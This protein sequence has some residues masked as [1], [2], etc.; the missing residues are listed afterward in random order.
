MLERSSRAHSRTAAVYSA[1]MAPLV[2]VCGEALIDMLPAGPVPGGGAANTAIALARLGVQVEFVGGLSRDH[3]GELLRAHLA[4]NGVALNQV[5]ESD[6]PTALALI[7]VDQHGQAQYTFSLD[8]TATFTF[9]AQSLP[10]SEPDVLHIGSLVTIVEPAASA[11]YLWAATKKAP[12]LFDPN[13]RPAVVNDLAR[14]RVSVERWAAIS[15]VIKLSDEDLRTLYP[16]LDEVSAVARLLNHKVELL[17]LT[18]GGAG[19]SAFTRTE[20]ISVPGVPVEVVDTVG[21]GDTVGAILVEAMTH[22]PVSALTRTRLEGVLQRAARAAAM[23]CSRV[24]CQP[25]TASELALS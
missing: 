8:Q 10:A 4:E 9:A 15:S 23:T 24:G 7:T 21:A 20:T 25:P 22:T 17:V 12:I 19:L 11:C 13:V 6:L 2:W 14:Y 5:I 18:R 1:D 3:H 16:E